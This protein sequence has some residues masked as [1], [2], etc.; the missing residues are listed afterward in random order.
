MG[1]IESRLKARAAELGFT[2]SGIAPATEAD[3]FPRY[4][5]WLDRGFA[6]AMDYLHRLGPPRRHPSSILESAR[7]VVMLGMEYGLGDRRQETGDGEE[8]VADSPSSP[9]P[10]SR[11]LAPARKAAYAAGP[12]YHRF[13]WDRINALSDWL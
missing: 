5:H 13:I 2:L 9:A 6:G 8:S 7:S 4:Q 12:D 3:G 11:P 10:V 1:P